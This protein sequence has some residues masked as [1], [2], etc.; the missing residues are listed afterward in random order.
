MKKWLGS[1]L[2]FGMFFWGST[3]ALATNNGNGVYN[4]GQMLPYMK[5]VHP[6]LTKNQIKEMYNDCNSTFRS[7]QSHTFS[8]SMMQQSMQNY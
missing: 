5:Q 7:S 3:A 8:N 2:V 1:L 6:D 4:F